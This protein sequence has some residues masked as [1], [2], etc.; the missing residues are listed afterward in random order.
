[1][2][3]RMIEC[4][5]EQKAQKR[6]ASAAISVLYLVHFEIII[7]NLF[8][9]INY[10]LSHKIKLR[11]LSPVGYWYKFAGRRVASE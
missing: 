6:S 7:F 1:M 2:L 3:N 5:V 4:S 9:Y 11:R 10:S 8:E